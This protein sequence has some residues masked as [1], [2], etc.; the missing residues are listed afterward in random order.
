[1]NLQH[2]SKIIFFFIFTLLILLPIIRAS[3]ATTSTYTIESYSTATAVS[4]ASSSSYNSETMT[5]GGQAT[6]GTTTTYTFSTTSS[7]STETEETDT[8]E[9]ATSSSSSSSSSSGA[10]ISS[11]RTYNLD[12]T[13]EGIES[14]YG[15]DDTLIL[16]V[17]DEEFELQITSISKDS[18]FLYI[19]DMDITISIS[20]GHTKKADLNWDGVYDIFITPSNIEEDESVTLLIKLYSVEEDINIEEVEV[21]TDEEQEAIFEQEEKE[22]FI[23]MLTIISII[24]FVIFLG[25]YLYFILRKKH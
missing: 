19:I 20:E 3:N 13:S 4:N 1:M 10:G 23:Q 21:L 25:I 18:V 2:K 5:G 22:D 9:D 17:G 16:T 24:V 8:T 12:I 14:D 7:P 15:E 11:V 6:N